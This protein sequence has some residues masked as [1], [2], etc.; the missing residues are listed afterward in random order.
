MSPHLSFRSCHGMTDELWTG[1]SSDVNLVHSRRQNV[2]S[3]GT[4]SHM[5]EGTIGFR[6]MSSRFGR[7][8][9]FSPQALWD[10]KSQAFAVLPSWAWPWT[11][12]TTCRCRRWPRQR[13]RCTGTQADGRR[14]RC[15]RCRC[16]WSCRLSRHPSCSCLHHRLR[17]E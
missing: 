8:C 9:V 2:A 10:S 5:L 12:W 3:T 14:S 7:R 16:R 1:F 4:T 15:P 13:R 17:S 11:S 6:G